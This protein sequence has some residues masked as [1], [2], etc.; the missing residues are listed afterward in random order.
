MLASLKLNR[1]TAGRQPEKQG[2]IDDSNSAGR[3]AP[4]P[5]SLQRS[6]V[7]QWRTRALDHNRPQRLA[8]VEIHVDAELSVT[9][10]APLDGCGRYTG[11]GTASILA[12]AAPV[13]LGGD[14][15]AAP[16]MNE[17]NSRASVRRVICKN[18]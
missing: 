7:K 3:G 8:G 14:A 4:L 18:I 11:F 2:Q 17:T 10:D 13:A 12:R 1:G 9:L 6:F 16:P 15:L 5:K